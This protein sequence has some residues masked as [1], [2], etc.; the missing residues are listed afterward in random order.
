[1]AVLTT[2]YIVLS[3]TSIPVPSCQ[4][5]GSDSNSN[6]I[7]LSSLM[8]LLIDKAAYEVI[9]VWFAF[10]IGLECNGNKGV[11]GFS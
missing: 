5:F 11:I 3:S 10:A 2:V 6:G 1:M 9:E 7:I 8:A 4:G